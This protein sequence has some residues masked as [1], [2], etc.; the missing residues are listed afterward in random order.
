LDFA[1]A[2]EFIHNYTLIHDDL[3]AMDD[4]AWRRGKPSVHKKFGE[5]C[6]ILAGDAMLT[7]AFEILARSPNPEAVVLA[8]QAAGA[9]GVVQGQAMDL[10]LGLHGKT[11]GARFLRAMNSLKTGRIFEAAVCGAALLGRP[12]PSFAARAALRR[13]SREFGL[14]FQILDD[15]K[16]AKGENGSAL[17]Q[18]DLATRL[19]RL[20][21]AAAKLPI[22]SNFRQ[23]LRHT[24]EEIFDNPNIV[25]HDGPD[26]FSRGRF[27]GLQNDKTASIESGDL[28]C[29]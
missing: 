24:T 22:P 8:A 3:P 25:R 19:R 2:I 13:W 17:S 18:R 9:R 11:R 28:F 26:T 15:L 29:Q 27:G 5:A 16:D 4:D 21:A 12:K 23:V 1:C 14:C 20:E 7:A 10:G 6:A